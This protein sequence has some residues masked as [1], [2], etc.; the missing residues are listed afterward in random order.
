MAAEHAPHLMRQ[1]GAGFLDH[2]EPHAIYENK[3]VCFLNDGGQFAAEAGPVDQVELHPI[4]D[5]NS[6]DLCHIFGDGGVLKLL[7]ALDGSLMSRGDVFFGLRLG[8][9]LHGLGQRVGSESF[10]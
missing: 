1:V 5:F 8:R 4:A 6:I 2:L 7:L 9:V 10:R 3:A